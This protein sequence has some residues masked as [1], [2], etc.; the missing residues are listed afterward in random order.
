MGIIADS[1]QDF[2][3]ALLDKSVHPSEI[4]NYSS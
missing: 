2:K 4:T 1:L 3:T